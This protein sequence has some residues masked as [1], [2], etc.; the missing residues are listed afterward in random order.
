VNITLFEK[1]NRIGGRTLTINPYDNPSL[2]VE[3]GASIFIE[4]NHILYGAL[5]EFNLSKRIPDEY[6]DP[7]LGIWDGEKFVFTIDERGP[8][9]WTAL[10][11]IWKYGFM[12]PRRTQKLMQ[13]TINKFLRMYEEP[14]FPF[15]S[16]TQRAHELGLVE[17]TAVTGQKLLKANK[18]SRIVPR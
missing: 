6:K 11:V 5:Q 17:I 12:A 16:L 2:R 10:K 9:W 18:V 7:V 15:R 3:L 13:T 4:K 1:T 8:F 14:F